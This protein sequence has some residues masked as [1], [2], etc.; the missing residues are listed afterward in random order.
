MASSL[1]YRPA[2]RVARTQ[3]PAPKTILPAAL[4]LPLTTVR[5]HERIYV[6]AAELTKPLDHLN[7]ADQVD[8]AG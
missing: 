3:T 8:R 2:A 7:G 4:M 1:Y 5:Q 6:E